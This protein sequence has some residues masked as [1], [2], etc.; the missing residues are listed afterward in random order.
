MIDFLEIGK[1]GLF[2]IA[3]YVYFR[4]FNKPVA[5]EDCLDKLI[6]FKAV[7]GAVIL[8]SCGISIIYNELARYFGWV[9]LFVNK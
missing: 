5:A 6:D 8:V 4:F 7:V 2:L 9:L 3:A 1:G